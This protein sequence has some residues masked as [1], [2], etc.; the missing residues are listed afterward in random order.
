MET[1]VPGES[2]EIVPEHAV[3]EFNSPTGSAMILV[4][5]MVGS[6]AR[7]KESSTC[8]AISKNA[9]MITVIQFGFYKAKTI[10]Y[11][12]SIQQVIYTFVNINTQG[13]KQIH[14]F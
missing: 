12:V 1:G 10:R 11:S 2:G 4:P 3:E 8:P 13:L 7:G 5:K 6:T 14:T 9:P